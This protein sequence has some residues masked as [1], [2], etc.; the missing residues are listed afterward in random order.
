MDIHM[1]KYW[2]KQHIEEKFG[3][4]NSQNM[5]R[6]TGAIVDYSQSDPQVSPLSK[7]HPNEDQQDQIKG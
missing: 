4:S 7:N 2:Y 6:V 5:C 3:N 1:A